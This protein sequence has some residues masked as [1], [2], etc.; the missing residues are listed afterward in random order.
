MSIP[1]PL[2]VRF[3]NRKKNLLPKPSA[4]FSIVLRLGQGC[5]WLAVVGCGWIARCEPATILSLVTAFLAAEEGSLENLISALEIP[6]SIQ[7][8]CGRL[9]LDQMNFTKP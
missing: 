7:L 4:A 5:F 9:N 2:F 3:H 1:L 6:R 8:S